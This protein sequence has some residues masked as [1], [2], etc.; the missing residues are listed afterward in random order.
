MQTFSL[1]IFPGEKRDWCF[2]IE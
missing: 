1:T 2:D